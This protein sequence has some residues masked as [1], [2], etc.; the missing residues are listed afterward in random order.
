[1]FVPSNGCNTNCLSDVYFVA[2]TRS[3]VDHTRNMV[4]SVFQREKRTNTPCVPDYFENVFFFRKIVQLL[5]KCS[6]DFFVFG[7][8][9]YSYIKITSFVEQ[10]LRY[11]VFVVCIWHFLRQHRLANLANCSIGNM[12]QNSPTAFI[13]YLC[14]K[15]RQLVGNFVIAA[16]NLCCKTRELVGEFC[17]I[18]NATKLAN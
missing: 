18:C 7:T 3:L 12:L 16:S 9:G 8:K 4:H 1:M 15:T 2:R 11:N 6:T 14:C 10:P 17:S 5:E 13:C